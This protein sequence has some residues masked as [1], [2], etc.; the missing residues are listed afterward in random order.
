MQWENLTSLDFEKAV[1]D[2]QGVGIISVGVIEAHASH[3]PL[4]T[5]AIA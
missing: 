5:D 4:G 1:T 3:L 2:C